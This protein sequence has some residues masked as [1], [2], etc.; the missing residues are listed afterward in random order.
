M[1]AQ[2]ISSGAR[3]AALVCGW[4]SPATPSRPLHRRCTPRARQA[5]GEGVASQQGAQAATSPQGTPST[6]AGRDD[7]NVRRG[8]SG[9]TGRQNERRG[10]HCLEG[11]TRNPRYSA[12][13]WVRR[14]APRTLEAWKSRAARL[15]EAERASTPEGAELSPPVAFNGL[16]IP[17]RR[18]ERNEAQDSFPFT[19][20]YQTKF[21]F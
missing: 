11:I 8:V 13:R 15:S 9:V 2:R 7:T 1:V 18:I 4:H 6:Q 19:W 21:P 5:R 16:K 20:A 14:L 3:A 17:D 12:G 10:P